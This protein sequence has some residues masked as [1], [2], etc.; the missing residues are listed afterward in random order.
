MIIFKLPA[1]STHITQPLDVGIFELKDLTWQCDR[2]G[3][4]KFNRLSFLVALQD[5]RASLF[6][7]GTIRNA[8]RRCVLMLSNPNVVLGPMKAKI[9]ENVAIAAARPVTPPPN[10]DECLQRTPRGP[11][12]YNQNILAPK[13][14]YVMHRNFNIS[15]HQMTRYEGPHEWRRYRNPFL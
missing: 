2:K 6:I 10:P 5:I 15:P 1:H 8:W 11:D 4:A 3:D 12:S 7:K 13:E 14:H 9:T